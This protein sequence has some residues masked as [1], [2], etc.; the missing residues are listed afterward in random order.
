MPDGK[1]FYTSDYDERMSY[2]PALWKIKSRQNPYDF[3]TSHGVKSI[4]QLIREH[5]VR[6]AIDYGCGYGKSM[7]DAVEET[8][9]KV[10]KFDP[11]VDPFKRYPTGTFDMVVVYNVLNILEPG[12]FD[13]VLDELHGLAERFV[14][15][16][17]VTSESRDHLWYIKR[18]LRYHSSRFRIREMNHVSRAEWFSLLGRMDSTMG[19]NDM[20]HM[21]YLLLEKI[22]TPADGD[23][24]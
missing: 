6:S 12:F 3:V 13:R 10:Y 23:G 8:G 11:F 7:D 15:A 16:N 17:I 5:D 22:N 14:V 19:D 18:L 4:A 1:K 9:I 20:R 2:Q 21:L 24:S